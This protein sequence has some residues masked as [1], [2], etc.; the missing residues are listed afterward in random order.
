MKKCAG[1]KHYLSDCPHT[2][3]EEAMAL[4]SEYKKK[5]DADKKKANFKTLG[6][7]GATS[8]TRPRI[9]RQRISESRS[10]Y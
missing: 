3:K 9:S 7:N 6:N 4:L 2:G 10:R 8:E 1:E 5:R